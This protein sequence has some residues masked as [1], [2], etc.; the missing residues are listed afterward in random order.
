MD[1]AS[2][3]MALSQN[4]IMS[5]VN[6]AILGKSLDMADTV[7]VNLTDMIDSNPASPVSPAGV[8]QN[9]DISI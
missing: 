8:G 6:V 7:S 4:K 9:I 5:D 3:S 1:I 2:V